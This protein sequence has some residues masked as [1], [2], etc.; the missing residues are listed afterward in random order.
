MNK[1]SRYQPFEMVIFRSVR[2]HLHHI[3]LAYVVPIVSCFGIFHKTY[4]S[5]GLPAWSIPVSYTHLASMEME[6]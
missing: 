2:V 4:A 1:K 5:L 3:H 6:P